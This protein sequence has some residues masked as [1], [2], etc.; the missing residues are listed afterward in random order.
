MKFDPVAFDKTISV[1]S[2]PVTFSLNR[3]VT[4]IL[5]RLVGLFATVDR[6]I[7]G[8]TLSTVKGVT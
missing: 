6:V 5:I 7:V 1:S 4:G 3:T 2:K 8:Q